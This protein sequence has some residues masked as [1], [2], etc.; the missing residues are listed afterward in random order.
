MLSFMEII[1]AL[2]CFV[3]VRVPYTLLRIRC[4]MR[5]KHIDVKY[6]YV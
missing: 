6:N 1:V 5:T 2:I 3:T 4:F